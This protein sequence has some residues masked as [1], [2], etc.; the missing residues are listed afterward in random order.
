M[1]K[2]AKKTHAMRVLESRGIPYTAT[3][4]DDGGTF[5]SAEEAAALLGVPV[6]AVYKTLVVMREAP[7][8]KPLIV[9]L[10]SD[11]Q[12]DLKRL[13]AAVGEKSLRMATQREA[14]QLTGMQVG[15]ISALGLK[16]PVG[17]V[18]ID[19]RA[20]VLETVH[21]SA[22]ER[23]TDIALQTADLVAASGAEYVAT[24]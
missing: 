11:A 19:E 18:Y 9:M 21:V 4:Y 6:A 23:G 8:A 7:R 20:R 3:T 12:L 10:P 1:A 24:S 16:R 17:D 15:G 5:H 2:P 22:G 14:E 13:A